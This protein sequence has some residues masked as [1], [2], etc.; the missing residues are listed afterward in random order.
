L[1]TGVGVNLI[2]DAVLIQP[3]V[4]KLTPTPEL[5]TGVV[6]LKELKAFATDE[7]R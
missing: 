4:D 1:G 5:I 2:T 7:R 6:D 3:V